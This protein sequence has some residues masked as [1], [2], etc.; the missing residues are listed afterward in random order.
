M[1]WLQSWGTAW[2]FLPSEQAL[3][4]VDNHDNQRGHGSGSSNILT[5]KSPKPYYVM[6]TAFLLAHSFGI[7]RVMSSFHFE[8]TD[9]GSNSINIIFHISLNTTSYCRS[10]KRQRRSHNF[11]GIRCKWPMRKWLGVRASL[12][13]HTQHGWIQKCGSQCSSRQFLE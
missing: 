13:G 2:G 7:P 10:A 6:A 1:K 3:V 4:F 11:A 9:Q 12:A 8:A 5:H